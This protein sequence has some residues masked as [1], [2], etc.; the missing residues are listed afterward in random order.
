MALIASAQGAIQ[1]GDF[2]TA[3][4]KLDE[5]Q[6]TFPRGVL[7]EERTAARVVALCGAGRQGEARSLGAAFLAR[8]PN[9]PLAPRVRGSCAGAE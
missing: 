3:L 6:R 2:A 8:H 4:A 9:S 1:R 7:S 5:H